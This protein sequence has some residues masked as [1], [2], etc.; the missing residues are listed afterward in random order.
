[1]KTNNCTIVQVPS[2]RVCTNP[3]VW[4]G[5]CLPHLKDLYELLPHRSDLKEIYDALASR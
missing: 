3:Q 5:L 2:G 1:M 4:N